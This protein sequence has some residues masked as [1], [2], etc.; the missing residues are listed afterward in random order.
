M[1][2][3]KPRRS[4]ASVRSLPCKRRDEARPPHMRVAPLPATGRQKVLTRKTMAACVLAASMTGAGT[5]EAATAACE[6]FR[7]TEGG[8]MIALSASEAA[9]LSAE[10][11][12][13]ANASGTRSSS[14]ASARGFGSVSSSSSA[15]ASSSSR[16]G[17]TARAVSSF[18]DADGNR[19]TITR[20]GLGCRIIV[21]EQ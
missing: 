9:R 21:D 19:I 1:A 18:T 7:I 4:I 11:G 16:G 2:G 20:D 17:G 10:H 14:S 3:R 8:R 6:A 15:S 5:S 12:V 13:R